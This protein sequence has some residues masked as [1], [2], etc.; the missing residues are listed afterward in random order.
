[1]VGSFVCWYT[2][3]VNRQSKSECI[4]DHILIRCC[5]V[6]GNNKTNNMI[7]KFHVIYIYLCKISDGLSEKICI[8][9]QIQSDGYQ[10]GKSMTHGISLICTVGFKSPPL[11]LWAKLNWLNLIII[12]HSRCLVR[13]NIVTGA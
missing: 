5:L 13:H 12:A 7:F 3:H 6:D 1:M 2:V 10:L 11:V 4:V 9:F 8:F